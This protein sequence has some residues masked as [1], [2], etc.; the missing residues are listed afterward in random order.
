M[1]FLTALLNFL[2][3]LAGR[4]KSERRKQEQEQHQ[5]ESQAVN[6]RPVEWFEN[7]FNNEDDKS[8]H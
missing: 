2:N 3:S 8:G 7:H 6:D 5:K 1:K 4:L